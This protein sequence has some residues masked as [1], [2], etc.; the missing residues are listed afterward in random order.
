M[1]KKEQPKNVISLSVYKYPLF[2]LDNFLSSP[3]AVLTAIG[4]YSWHFLAIFGF[5]LCRLWSADC[6]DELQPLWEGGERICA[7]EPNAASFTVSARHARLEDDIAREIDD[8]QFVGQRHM[9]RHLEPEPAA[10]GVCHCTRNDHAPLIVHCARGAPH[11]LA[12]AP[13]CFVQSR[14]TC[15][16]HRRLQAHGADAGRLL[17]LA[18]PVFS[19]T[20]YQTLNCVKDIPLQTEEFNWDQKPKMHAE[21]RDT[22]ESPPTRT[23]AEVS[24]GKEICHLVISMPHLRPAQ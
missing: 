15:L 20:Q 13:G 17:E 18:S 3:V 12:G 8:E 2:P 1:Q 6:S 9:R 24:D 10:R 14:F 23:R 11:W 22:L 16:R 4:Y 7:L 19:T 5:A 21:T